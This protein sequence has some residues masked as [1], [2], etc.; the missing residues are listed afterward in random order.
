[1]PPGEWVQTSGWH[2]P[3]Q[4]VERR[5]LTRQEIDAVA[6]NNPVFV[7][8]VG[9]FAMAN[10]KALE[11][12]GITRSTLDPVGGK[13]YR[14]ANGDATGLLEE[15]AIDLVEHKIPKPTF[16]QVVAQLVTAQRIYN[17]SGITSTIDAALSEDQMRAYFVV[18]QRK[19]ATVR[20]GLMWRPGAATAEEF[21]RALKAAQFKENQGDDW[22][23][24][25]GIKIVSDGGITLR[26]AYTRQAYAGEP[27]NHGTLAVDAAAY[28]QS[29]VLANR[30]GWRV[31]THAVGDAAV[32]LVLDAY[33]AAD[34]DRSIKDSRYIIIHGSLM[35]REQILRANPRHFE[36]LFSLGMIYVNS[37][38]FEE[39][40]RILSDALKLNPRFGEG[41]CARGIVLL[42][43]R[44]R[45]EALAC[46]DQSLALVP[47]FLEA[48]SSRA[49]ALLEIGRHDEALAAF[50]RVLALR[51]DH[52]ISWNNRGNTFVAMRRLEEAVA[53][54]MPER[55]APFPKSQSAVPTSKGESPC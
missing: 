10:T 26:S 48:L 1:V 18:A 53:S 14:D 5:Y 55:R 52:A 9:H 11:L 15:T 22:V 47:D 51:P 8:T 35:T 49:T 21:E 42:H 24:V 34:K 2:P 43:L 17:R 33:T 20:A 38:Q 23:R 19:Q 44:R 16:E 27:D 50:D 30:Y 7:Q 54:G 39:G 28:K 31:G 12:G 37:E 4:L 3:S 36:A 13:I 32:D 46:F 40:Q 29:V 25:S 41:W 45:E 6:P